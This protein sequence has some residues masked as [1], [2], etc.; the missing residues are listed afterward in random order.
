MSSTSVNGV[1]KTVGHHTYV[2]VAALEQLSPHI[3]RQVAAAAQLCGINPVDHFN[4]IKYDT[5][6][7]SISLLD[8]A[9]FFESAF[10][11]LR[12]SWTTEPTHS[13]FRHRTYSQ[14]LN[15]PILHRKELLLPSNYPGRDAFENLTAAAEQIGLF[16]DTARIGFLRSWEQLLVSKGFRVVGHT[17]TP[18]GN[19]ESSEP[20]PDT[21]DSTAIARHRTALT[22][23]NFSAPVQSLA[24]HG[25]LDGSWSFFD[26]GCG[27]GDDLRGLQENRISAVGWDPY[28]APEA[29]K[30]AADLVNLGFVI[31]VIEDLGERIEA[32]QGAYALARRLLVVAAMI[33]SEA[34]ITGL[35]YGDGIVTSRRT[36]QKYYGQLELRQFI[37][38]VLDEE[39]LAVAPGIFYVFKDK[40]AEQR[41]QYGR[42]ESRRNR[43][44]LTPRSPPQRVQRVSS[45]RLTAADKARL[46][47]TEAEQWL[48]PVWRNWIDLGR[49]PVDEE[50]PVHQEIVARFGSLNAALNLIRSVHVEEMD[51]VQASAASRSDDLRVY[52]ARLHFER[53]RTYHTLEA[54][55]QRDVKAF[56]GSFRVAQEAAQ[57]LL[58][59]LSNAQLIGETCRKAADSGLGWYVEGESLQVHSS[60]VPQL[61]ALLRIYIECATLLYGDVSSADLL[62]IH[63]R[64]SKLTLMRFDSFVE[65]ALPRMTH[66]IKINLRTQELESF[67]YIGDH[68]PPYLY[69]KSRFI[70]EEFPHYAEQ[71]HLEESLDAMGLLRFPGYGPTVRDFTSLLERRRLCIDGFHL[72]RSTTLPSLAAPCGRYFTFGD[73]V[74][75][76]ETVQRLAP[77]NIPRESDT[78]NALADLAEHVLDPTIDY[79]GMIKLTYGFCSAALAGEIT[80]RIAPA[81]DQHAAH[82]LKRNGQLICKRMGAACD[83]LVEDEDMEEVALWVAANTPFDRLYYYGKDRPIHVSF[84]PEHQ[85]QFVEMRRTVDNRQ[86]P[87]VRRDVTVFGPLQVTL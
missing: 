1:G 17:L 61:P 56:F 23:Y 73:L 34:S 77:E 5:P 18:V 53:R 46:K 3:R 20:S 74:Q 32:L 71:I 54:Q 37:T 12:Q 60:M 67:D 14:S 25:F 52:F 6:L 29:P 40:D 82:E 8:Y 16:D 35:A 75:A 86:V 68:A 65:R 30:V 10:P 7:T 59:G 41:F 48:E 85:R 11:Q 38:E 19:D 51:L 83:F 36:F 55:L 42:L 21:G 50:V 80:E 81:L 15:P 24:R 78:F 2:H 44:Q 76:G 13:N 22:R 62:K 64:S 31:N 28:F 49:P 33:R 9:D 4:V 70:N 63:I 43:L 27:R 66:R 84:G 26:Y 69:E 72:K 57:E 39:P 47:Y 79:F 87:H 45:P 58:S